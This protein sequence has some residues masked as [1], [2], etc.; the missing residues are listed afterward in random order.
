MDDSLSQLVDILF[1]H[2]DNV[3]YT[4]AAIMFSW[5]DKQMCTMSVFI[6]GK[7]LRQH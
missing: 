4:V 2:V 6:A 5:M 3:Y 1:S 7:Y